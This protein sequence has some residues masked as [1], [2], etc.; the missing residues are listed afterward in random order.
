MGCTLIF[1]AR[2]RSLGQ[3]NIFTP[4]CHSVHRGGLP[5]CMMGYPP[6]QAPSL[7]P[8]TPPDQA[9]PWPGIPLGDTVNGRAVRILLE[10]NLV[11][12][13]IAIPIHPIEKNRNRNRVIN[14]RCEWTFN[15][16]LT[17]R[18]FFVDRIER[19]MEFRYWLCLMKLN[20]KAN[21]IINNKIQGCLLQYVAYL[22]TSVVWKGCTLCIDGDI[23]WVVV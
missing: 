9:P 10:C 7:G 16:Y 12:V 1:T 8:G 23:A 19:L 15:G 21:R 14:I 22:W 20:G 13:A 17:L 6:D 4:V 11:A 5:Q 18:L 3:G 2:K